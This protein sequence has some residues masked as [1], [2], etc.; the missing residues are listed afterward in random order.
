MYEP[1]QPCDLRVKGLEVDCLREVEIGDFG[2]SRRSRSMIHLFEVVANYNVHVVIVEV[3]VSRQAC[4]RRVHVK[5]LNAL[6]PSE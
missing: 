3:L 6:P 4:E 2:D 5:P 1:R